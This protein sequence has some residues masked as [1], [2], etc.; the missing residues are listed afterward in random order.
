MYQLS[1]A[2]LYQFTSAGDTAQPHHAWL[3]TN[4]RG[5]RLKVLL[6]DGQGM[7]LAQRRLHQGR[8][9]W[10]TGEAAVTL[11]RQQFDALVLGLPWQQLGDGGVIRLL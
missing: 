1:I 5:N 4:R 7:W 8:F 9:H 2:G 10:Q 11:T 3:F 6:H